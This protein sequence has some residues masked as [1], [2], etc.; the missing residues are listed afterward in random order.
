MT[1]GEILF[2]VIVAIFLAVVLYGPTVYEWFDKRDLA[3]R[4]LGRAKDRTKLMFEAN[5][6]KRYLMA[7]S[8]GLASPN[9]S[10]LPSTTTTDTSSVDTSTWAAMMFADSSASYSSNSSC[11]S[12]SDSSSSCDSSSDSSS[13]SCDSGGGCDGGGGSCD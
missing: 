9:R 1:A 3:K 6:E 4:E 2:Y 13:S 8:S 5:K 7:S 12:S 10:S 11:D